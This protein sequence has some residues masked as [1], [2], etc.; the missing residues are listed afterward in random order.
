LNLT[1]MNLTMTPVA[2]RGLA[3]AILLALIGVLYYGVAAPLFESY[4]AAR[5]SITQLQAALERYQRLGRE[6]A[7]R[8]A[9][10]AALKQQQVTQEG[11]LE[12][13]SETLLA[14]Q[15]QNRIKTFVEQA[16]GEL[17]G[18]QVLPAENEGKL[19]RI[20]VRGQMLVTLP[21]AQRIF[22]GLESASPLL[23]L[24]N[25]DMR[26]WVSVRRHADPANQEVTFDI[27]FDVVGYT[28]GAK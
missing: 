18:T 24:D 14:A 21:A 6:L 26:V 10:L 7:P 12:G 4:E 2:S 28:R 8:Q 20:I 3:L 16:H 13:A 15:I 19:R 5:Q 27:K 1:T 23:F 17:Q 9:E 22:Y 25:V 11:F